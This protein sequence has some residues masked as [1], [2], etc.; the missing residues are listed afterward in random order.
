MA[1]KP[2]PKPKYSKF[3][4]PAPGSDNDPVTKALKFFLGDKSKPS[5]KK[6]GPKPRGVKLPGK[7]V[8]LAEY[9]PNRAPGAP[10]PAP[11]PKRVPNLSLPVDQR[12]SAKKIP[13]GLRKKGKSPST[14]TPKAKKPTLDDFLT[15]GK[16]P[17]MKI[18]PGLK[19]PSDADVIIKGYN[20]KKYK[21]GK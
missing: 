18:K 7:P 17:P 6:N 9:K 2:T 13:P 16:K 14:A 21:K 5:G 1:T 8:P 3:A 20:D 12:A 10:K 4:K 15:K 19:R 11:M